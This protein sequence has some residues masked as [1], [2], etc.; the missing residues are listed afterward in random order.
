M[1]KETTKKKDKI[2]LFKLNDYSLMLKTVD[3]FELCD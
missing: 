3:L 1:Q 2:L